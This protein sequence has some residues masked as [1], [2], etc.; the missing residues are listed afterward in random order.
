MRYFCCVVPKIGTSAIYYG[1]AS[2]AAK[3]WANVGL[4]CGSLST[5]FLIK[6]RRGWGHHPGISGLLF[7]LRTDRAHWIGVIPSLN[8]AL[9]GSCVSK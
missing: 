6:A 8:Y 9:K 2:R 7:S 4:E 1:M 3:I 5:Q